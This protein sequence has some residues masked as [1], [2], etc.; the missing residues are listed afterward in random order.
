MP[1]QIHDAVEVTSTVK[2]SCLTALRPL[3]VYQFRRATYVFMGQ[4]PSAVIGMTRELRTASHV[5][6]T[7]ASDV[8]AT[9]WI[10]L[11]IA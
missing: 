6:P 3:S 5:T 11:S 4:R 10:S 8:A 7:V 9:G 2:L 1:A